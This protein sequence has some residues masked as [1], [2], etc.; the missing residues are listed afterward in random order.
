MPPGEEEGI[1]DLGYLRE[2]IHSLRTG[3]GLAKVEPLQ[4]DSSQAELEGR[5]GD[6]VASLTQA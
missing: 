3:M 2:V 4:C 5:K 1:C 6:W